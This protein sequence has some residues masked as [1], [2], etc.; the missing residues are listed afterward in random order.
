MTDSAPLKPKPCRK[1]G[2]AGEVIKAGSRRYWVECARYGRNGN[3]NSIGDQADNR[4]DA[5]RNWNAI[6]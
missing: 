2:S 3:C 5:I 1:C 6:N 4:R